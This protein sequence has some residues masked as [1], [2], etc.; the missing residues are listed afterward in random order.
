[1]KTRGSP[2]QRRLGYL[3]I[4]VTTI[5]IA[6]VVAMFL[7]FSYP[8]TVLLG[9]VPPVAILLFFGYKM[10]SSVDEEM[11]SEVRRTNSMKASSSTLVTLFC[12]LSVDGFFEIV[13]GKGRPVIYLAV[14]GV[15]FFIF[16][17]YYN[18]K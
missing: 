3:F 10:L 4:S 16:Y 6:V 2:R 15:S 12:T 1:M 13:P 7:Y 5:P 9:A 8:P 17:F 11:T 14:G 18:V